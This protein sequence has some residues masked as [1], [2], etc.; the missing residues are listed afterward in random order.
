V[1][2]SLYHL[3]FVGAL[4]LGIMAMLPLLTGAL[5]GIRSLAIGGTAMLI[6]VSVAIDFMK[7]IDAQLSM[8]EY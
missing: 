6:V 2:R 7:Q 5:T 1:A 4:F 8:R 3:T